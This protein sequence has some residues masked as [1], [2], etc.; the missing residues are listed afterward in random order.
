MFYLPVGFHITPSFSKFCSVGNSKAA[1]ILI[2]P[3]DDP[4]IVGR[5]VQ[6]IPEREIQFLILIL[7]PVTL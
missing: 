6:E 3:G 2:Y 4:R 1:N 5:I 7:S